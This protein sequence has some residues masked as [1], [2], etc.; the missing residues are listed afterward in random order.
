MSTSAKFILINFRIFNKRVF[1]DLKSSKDATH[2]NLEVLKKSIE[3]SIIVLQK[4]T[5]TLDIVHTSKIK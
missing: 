5:V 2:N 4:V 3:K 1:A